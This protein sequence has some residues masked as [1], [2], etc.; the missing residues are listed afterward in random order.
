MFCDVTSLVNGTTRQKLAQ[1]DMRKMGIPLPPF[2][3]QC[4]IAAALDKVSE[5][6]AKRHQQL[7]KLE[8]LKNH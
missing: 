4:N 1:A 2:A 5:L 7:G 8:I 6:I 3:E